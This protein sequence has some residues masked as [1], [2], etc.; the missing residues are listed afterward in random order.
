M[1]EKD[2]RWAL[3]ERLRWE[4]EELE[5]ARNGTRNS[6][7]IENFGLV[8]QTLRSAHRDPK[9]TDKAAEFIERLLAIAPGWYALKFRQIRQ[10]HDET[11]KALIKEIEQVENYLKGLKLYRRVRVAPSRRKKTKVRGFD[12]EDVEILRV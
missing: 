8:R 3:R 10:N 6:V 4:R 9:V 12:L 5:H 7:D 1:S 2:I 11:Y